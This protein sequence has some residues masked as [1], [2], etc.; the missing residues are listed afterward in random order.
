MLQLE[1][2]MGLV[3]CRN[4]LA[5]LNTGQLSKFLKK[6]GRMGGTDGPVYYWGYVLLEKIRIWEG[7]KQT[8]SRAETEKK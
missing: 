5:E 1:E 7:E 4:Q 6:S 2:D 3:G 8:K